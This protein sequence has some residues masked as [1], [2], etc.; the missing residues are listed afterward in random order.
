MKKKIFGGI[1]VLAIAAVALF[2]A[3]FGSKSSKL[4]SVS[5]ANV[6]ALAQESSSNCSDGIPRTTCSIWTVTYSPLDMK[7]DCVTGGCYQCT[8]G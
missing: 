6:E 3:N 5:L 1:A 8:I 4:S 2:N 7:Y